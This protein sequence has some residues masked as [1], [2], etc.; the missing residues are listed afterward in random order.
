MLSYVGFFVTMA[1]A[2]A[3]LSWTLTKTSLFDWFRDRLPTE[4]MIAE[5][6]SCPYCVSHYIAVVIV[7]LY[8]PMPFTGVWIDLVPSVFALIGMSYLLILTFSLALQIIMKLRFGMM[9]KD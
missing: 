1:F 8:K 3:S 6:A 5:L 2:T 4:G 7:A 9:P